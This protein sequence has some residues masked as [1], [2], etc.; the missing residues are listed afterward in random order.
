MK[1]NFLQKNLLLVRFINLILGRN[2]T[3]LLIKAETNKDNTTLKKRNKPSFTFNELIETNEKKIA[4]EKFKSQRDWE[5]TQQ[6]LENINTKSILFIYIVERANVI[7][8]IY[9]RF[10]SEKLVHS[11]NLAKQIR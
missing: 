11:C 4:M 3:K 8:K 6:V 7:S 9:K 1:S 5:T 2:N 10:N